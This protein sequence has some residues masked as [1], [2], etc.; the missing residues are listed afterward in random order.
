MKILYPRLDKSNPSLVLFLRVSSS[1]GW[2]ETQK[3]K[4]SRP[5]RRKLFTRSRRS[6]RKDLFTNDLAYN[7]RVWNIKIRNKH[8]AVRTPSQEHHTPLNLWETEKFSCK[9]E[10]SWGRRTMTK[11]MGWSGKEEEDG[12]VEELRRNDNMRRMRMESEWDVRSDL[13]MVA[14]WGWMG[15]FAMQTTVGLRLSLIRL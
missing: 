9:P 2:I 15:S 13:L 12:E 6:R 3:Q 4:R 7:F 8:R 10:S 1:A 5:K 11:S 14:A